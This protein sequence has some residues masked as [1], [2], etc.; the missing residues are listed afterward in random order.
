M[1]DSNSN[2]NSEIEL[3]TLVKS[4]VRS[5]FEIGHAEICNQILL[6]HQT[7]IE[8]WYDRSGV[9]L[10]DNNHIFDTFKLTVIK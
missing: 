4:S 2:I 9:L 8:I 6:K 1:Q 5:S 10:K 7:A 3:C